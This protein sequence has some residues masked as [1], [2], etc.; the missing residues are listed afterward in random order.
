MSKVKNFLAA[1]GYHA[2]AGSHAN[3]WSWASSG[4]PAMWFA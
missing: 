3:G 1:T 4:V 2:I